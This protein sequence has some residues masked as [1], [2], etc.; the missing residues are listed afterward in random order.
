[1]WV[2]VNKHLGFRRYVDVHLTTAI[3]LSVCLNFGHASVDRKLSIDV[4]LFTM[5]A[6]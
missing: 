5:A 6:L 4:S 2:K 1:M 3:V